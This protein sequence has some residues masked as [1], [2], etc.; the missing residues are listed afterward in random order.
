MR[1][2]WRG[3]GRFLLCCA[4]HA[5]GCICMGARSP[6]PMQKVREQGSVMTTCQGTPVVCALR[7]LACAHAGRAWRPVR[8]AARAGAAEVDA[9]AAGSHSAAGSAPAPTTP[10]ALLHTSA[11]TTGR[12]E[13]VLWFPSEG[14]VALWAAPCMH[15]MFMQGIYCVHANYGVRQACARRGV[16]CSNA[17]GLRGYVQEEEKGKHGTIY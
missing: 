3:I 13:N 15:L 5:G 10:A 14:G 16:Q 4:A 17:P 6:G 2:G 11:F 12:R 9:C 8:C 7:G 1:G